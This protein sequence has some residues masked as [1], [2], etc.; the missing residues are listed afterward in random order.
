M[1]IKQYAEV[2]PDRKAK[3]WLKKNGW[4]GTDEHKT[5]HALIMHSMLIKIGIDIGSKKYYDSIDFYMAELNFF[6]L[7][8]GI[9][10]DRKEKAN[11][12]RA[13]SRDRLFNT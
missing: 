6:R 2:K 10:N 4:F 3:V 12:S 8:K 9:K 11:H 13:S 7:D 1:T 5:T